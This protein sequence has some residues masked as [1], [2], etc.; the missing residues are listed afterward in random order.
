MSVIKRLYA[1]R[2]L[3]FSGVYY[4]LGGFRKHGINLIGLFHFSAKR[5]P[6]KLCISDENGELSY[7]DLY[8]K[9]KKL[10][11]ALQEEFTIT[12]DSKIA[13]LC[14]NHSLSIVALGAISRLGADII[15]LNVEMSTDQIQNIISKEK[16]DLT[17][18]DNNLEEKLNNLRCRKLAC[19]TNTSDSV[20]SFLI[21][22]ENSDIRIKRQRSGNISVLTGGT[23]GKVKMAKRK[24]TISSLANPFFILLNKLQLDTK[25]NVYIGVPIYHGYGLASITLALILNKEI[26]VRTQFNT[27][28][29]LQLIET[30]KID[31]IITVPTILNRLLNEENEELKEV[32]TILSGGAA[33]ESSLIKRTQEKLGNILFNL[34]GTSESGF[35]VLASPQNLNLHSQ[36]IGKPIKGVTLKVLDNSSIPV[37]TNTIGTIHIKTSWSM[38]NVKNKYHTTGDMG[39]INSEGYIFLKGRV[40]DMIVSGGENVYPKDLENKILQHPN[41]K[42]VAVIGASNVE[43]GKRLVAYVVL[44]NTIMSEN[45]IEL[46][47]WLKTRVA[48]FQMPHKII[49]LSTLPFTQTGKLDKKELIAL[50]NIEMNQSSTV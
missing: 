12:K 25:K 48:R 45:S 43:F 8:D 50:Y 46:S 6:N 21:K 30:N 47:R 11:F 27:T 19:F 2:L 16:F 37:S 9:G 36:S 14:R 20:A 4:I 44:N 38:K 32:K 41:V 33:L 49:T 40:D 39:F 42:E 31:L 10:A 22:Y 24:P 13:I 23:S 15:F 35:S 7:F 5:T 34:Y 26:H 17:I 18:Y 1:V 28:D 29:T 3:S